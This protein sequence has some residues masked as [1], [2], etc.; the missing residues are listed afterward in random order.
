MV[1]FFMLE[2]IPKREILFTRLPQ[3]KGYQ[4]I[5]IK[6]DIKASLIIYLYLLLVL[7]HPNVNLTMY[8]DDILNN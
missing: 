5:K 7:L 2:D 6:E 3:A 1:S 4:E 8:C